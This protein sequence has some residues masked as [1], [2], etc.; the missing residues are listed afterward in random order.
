MCPTSN[1]E[2]NLN[3]IPT[4]KTFKYKCPNCGMVEPI[5]NA[6]N[7]FP[8]FNSKYINSQLKVIFLE[9]L[10]LELESKHNEDYDGDPAKEKSITICVEQIR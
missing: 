7:N 1:L 10:L 6:L 3:Q 4:S 2:I 5:Y 9:A 8:Y